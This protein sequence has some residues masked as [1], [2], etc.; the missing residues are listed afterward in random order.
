M[1]FLVTHIP[2]LAHDVPFLQS[3]YQCHPGSEPIPATRSRAVI[4]R[5][6]TDRVYLPS[7]MQLLLLPVL[8]ANSRKPS[9]VRLFAVPYPA[10]HE[11]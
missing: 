8:P 6:A 9:T 4:C 7:S 2:F 10:Y 11:T 5:C 1:Q 3:L